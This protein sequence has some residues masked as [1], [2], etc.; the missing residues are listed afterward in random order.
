[1]DRASPRDDPPRQGSVFEVCDHESRDPETHA[2]WICCGR[3][4]VKVTC[5]IFADHG[6]SVVVAA[7]PGQGSSVKARGVK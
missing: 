1:M 6:L 4:G 5:S 2:L 7:I 3:R